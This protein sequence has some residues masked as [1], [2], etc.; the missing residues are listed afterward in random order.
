MI[1]IGTAKPESKGKYRLTR[2]DMIF[3]M[4]DDGSKELNFLDE[5]SALLYAESIGLP[6]DNHNIFL[7]NIKEDKIVEGSK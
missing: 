5:G 4:K 7:Y 2:K 1:F 6:V 3:I